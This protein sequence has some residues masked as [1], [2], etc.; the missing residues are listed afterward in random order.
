MTDV[1]IAHIILIS[2]PTQTDR[3]YGTVF[4]AP[5]SPGGP[6]QDIAMLAVANGWAKVRDQGG[7]G[8]EAVR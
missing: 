8:E 7:E 5:A 4:A 3:E 1:L 2:L 6:P